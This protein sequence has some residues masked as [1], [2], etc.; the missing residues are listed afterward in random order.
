MPY[1]VRQLI[2]EAFRASTVRGIG[3]TP[4]DE[5]VTDALVLLND[6]LDSLSGKSGFTPGLKTISVKT[7]KDYITISNNK[8]K[9]IS[10]FIA[11]NLQEHFFATTEDNHTLNDDDIG[12]KIFL[13][14]KGKE[15]ECVVS[16]IISLTEFA[17]EKNVELS[18]VFS[19]ISFR[20]ENEDKIDVISVPPVNIEYV[21]INDSF[22]EELQENI[23]YFKKPS[24]GLWFFYDKSLYDATKLYVS[25]S[26][27]IE[28]TFREPCWVDLTLDS[29]LSNMHRVAR[30]VIK[31]KLAADIAEA[32]GY[33]EIADRLIA[34]SKS[35]L[36]T[37]QRDQMQLQAPIPDLSA[38]GYFN[39]TYNIYKDS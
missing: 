15:Y 9:I 39:G 19:K 10:S 12:K 4:D 22:A 33:L 31:W 37:F 6:A 21:K 16:G 11:D 18:G 13:N 5:E 28:I 32:N 24:Y 25:Q 17:V 29:D 34:R 20:F 30:Q 1:N 27:I 36:G 8:Q 3:D 23:F 35:A 2:T 7:S 26:G 14:I 38:H